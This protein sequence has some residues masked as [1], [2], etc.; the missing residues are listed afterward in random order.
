MEWDT[1]K[2][3]MTQEAANRVGDKI[4]LECEDQNNRKQE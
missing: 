4:S 3:R 2:R 1:D